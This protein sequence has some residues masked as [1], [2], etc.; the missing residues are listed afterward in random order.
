MV[1]SAILLT[2]PI[3]GFLTGT[4]DSEERTGG[5]GEVDFLFTVDTAVARCVKVGRLAEGEG[6]S[7][8]KRLRFREGDS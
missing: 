4:L 3:L 6:I 5:I 2:L 8:G 1:P 7:S